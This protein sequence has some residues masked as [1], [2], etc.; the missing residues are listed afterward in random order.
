MDG[1]GNGN[2]TLTVCIDMGGS[3]STMA[4]CAFGVAFFAATCY[5]NRDSRAVLTTM[6]FVEGSWEKS[7]PPPPLIITQS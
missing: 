7:T 5:F 1:N 6:V 4:G 3:T 2:G